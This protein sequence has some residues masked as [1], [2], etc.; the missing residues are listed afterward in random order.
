[1]K[2]LVNY[3]A[4]AF[5]VVSFYMPA[6]GRAAVNLESYMGGDGTIPT[7]AAKEIL[8]NVFMHNIDQLNTV[9]VEVS[10][11]QKRDNMNIAFV[12]VGRLEDF[13]NTEIYALI[14]DTKWNVID[15]AMLGV[16]GDTQALTIVT[17]HDEM[18]YQPNIDLGYILRGDTIKTQRTYEYYSTLR[19]G[20]TINKRGTIYNNLLIR[21]D[22]KLVMLP[23]QTEA[24]ETIGDANYLSKDH[25]QPV[26]HNTEGEFNG[27]GMNMIRISQIPVSSAIPMEEWN[28][29]AAMAS[30][31]LQ[32]ETDKRETFKAQ[33]CSKWLTNAGLRN[34]NEFLVWISQNADI[35]KIT[36]FI[37]NT[38]N[39]SGMGEAQWLQQRVKALKNKKTR[40]WWQ[41]WMKNNN[42][43][44]S[45]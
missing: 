12:Y 21:Q 6:N 16:E 23:A 4:L 30:E 26:T 34:G 8:A 27:Y 18:V 14:F 19:G 11:M 17:P 25:K 36:P 13:F 7:S 37:L 24:R 29:L 45:K 43:A 41:K 9:S 42:I 5:L 20:R 32:K 1:M 40:K 28:N 10:R 31:I 33:F 44:T 38:I 35:E 2:R 39:Q 15:G 22:G 3:L